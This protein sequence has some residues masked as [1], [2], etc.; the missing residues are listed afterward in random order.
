MLEDLWPGAGDGRPDLAALPSPAALAR[1][2]AAIPV[3]GQ[4]APL[5]DSASNAWAVSGARSTSGE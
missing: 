4:D 2:A 1:L 5:P 3:F